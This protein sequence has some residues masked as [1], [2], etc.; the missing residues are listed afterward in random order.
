MSLGLETPQLA[1][2]LLVE[3]N[4]PDARLIREILIQGR[5]PKNV[6]VVDGGDDALAF[7]RRTGPYATAPRP[8]LVV[9]D[10][11]LPGRDG[12]EVLREIKTDRSLRHIPV[13]VLTTSSA[14]TD[15]QHA[16][17]LHANAYIVKPLGLD[18]FTEVIRAVEDFW[19]RMAQ[20][21]GSAS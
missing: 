14:P 18:A 20:R 8:S 13:V 21:P 12:R 16:Y 5:V 10:L 3:D 1:E 17:E 19:L 6:R 15:V 7:L 4:R 9:L 11:N 2:V